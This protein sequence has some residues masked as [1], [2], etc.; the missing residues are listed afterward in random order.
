MFLNEFKNEFGAI[1]GEQN[2]IP[3]LGFSGLQRLKTSYL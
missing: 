3:I 1:Q 2:A